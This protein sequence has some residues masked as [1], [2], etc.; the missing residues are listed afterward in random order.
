MAGE[1]SSLPGSALISVSVVSSKTRQLV[2]DANETCALKLG[3]GR[4]KDDR[5]ARVWHASLG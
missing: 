5:A 2:A 1:L 3:A 4:L